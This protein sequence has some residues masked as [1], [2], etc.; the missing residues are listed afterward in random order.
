MFSCENI[1]LTHTHTRCYAMCTRTHWN[2]W[3]SVDRFA[4][5]II[6]LCDSII[7][8]VSYIAL[9]CLLACLHSIC[10][11]SFSS[12]DT[13]S[14]AIAYLPLT[15]HGA[16]TKR[17]RRYRYATA[18][19]RPTNEAKPFLLLFIHLF[20]GSFCSVTRRRRHESDDVR[21]RERL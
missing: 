21:R 16:D 7:F 11:F 1:Q 5:L 2:P 12:L 4:H 3:T 10:S 19:T 14:H 6:I 9:C 13:V 17:R 20:S 18:V 15:L 8:V